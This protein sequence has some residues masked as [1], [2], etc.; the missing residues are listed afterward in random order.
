MIIWEDNNRVDILILGCCECQQGFF[1]V[2]DHLDIFCQNLD[3]PF[4]AMRYT[5]SE[6]K[7]TFY[8]P[9]LRFVFIT[10]WEK[11]QLSYALLLEMPE[12]LL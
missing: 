5:L 11:W 12:G 3:G 4:V 1:K 7:K 6:M 2:S 8:P 9:K 10:D